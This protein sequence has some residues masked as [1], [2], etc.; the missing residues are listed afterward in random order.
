M[1]AIAKYLKPAADLVLTLVFWIWFIFG[2]LVF[3]FPLHLWAALFSKNRE[4]GFQKANHSFF[5]SFFRLVRT[6][7]PGLK[8]EIDERVA[9]IR[10]SIIVSNHVSYLDPILLVS[11]FER[12]KTIVKSTFFRVPVFGWI[13]NESGFIP[14]TTDGKLGGLMLERIENLPEY[15]ETG[16]NIFVFPEGRRSTDGRIG[17]FSPGVFK[18]AKKCRAPIKVLFV[19]NTDRLFR[20][21]SFIFDTCVENT[22]EVEYLGEILHRGMEGDHP[23]SEIV[24][25]VRSTMENR[26][27]LPRKAAG[28]VLP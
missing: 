1:P 6:A 15:L 2:Y 14:S 9:A 25:T 3:F 17:K 10:S 5:R 19:R 28:N 16:G 20:P 23:V 11:I 8:I 26:I 27:V 13:L 12:Q 4:L 22:V 18:I 21:G 24:S 7:T